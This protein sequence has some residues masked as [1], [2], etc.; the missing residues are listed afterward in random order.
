MTAAGAHR[1]RLVL[2]FGLTLSVLL[3]EVIGALASGSLALLADA[4]HLFTDTAGIGL[5]LGAMWVAGR[6]ATDSRTFGFL[7]LE[8]VAA[9]I[10][11]VLLVGVAVYVLVEAWRRFQDPP[12]I[13]TGLMFAIGLAGLAANAVS[14]VLLRNAQAGSLNL[15]GAYL[16][17]VADLAGSVA[18]I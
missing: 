2:V 8:I 12:P 7:R 13:A 6:P 9:A 16:E 15:R 11:A 4:G 5:A 1:R 17:V 18:V 10:N 3:V 14:V